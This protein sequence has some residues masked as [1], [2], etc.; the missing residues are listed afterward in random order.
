MFNAD[1]RRFDRLIGKVLD[2]EGGLIYDPADPGGLTHWGISLRSY[3]HLGVKGIRNLTQAQA[4][5]IYYRDWWL[6]L[7]C[8]QITDDRVAQKLLDTAVNVG[9]EP[10]V[11]IFQQSIGDVGTQVAVDGFMGPLTLAGAN[12]APASDLLAAIRVRQ[13]Q[14]Y[15]GLIARRPALAKFEQEWMKRATS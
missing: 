13:A 15:H 10:G 3:P 1:R 2:H 7:R 11:K 5:D 8:P 4:C 9:F 14:Y 12:R 6:P